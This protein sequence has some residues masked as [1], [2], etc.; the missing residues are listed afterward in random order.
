MLLQTSDMRN[1][2]SIFNFTQIL[3]SELFN[4]AKNKQQI[5]RS[6]QLTSISKSFMKTLYNKHGYVMNI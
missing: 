4:L 5:K 6:S 3:N 2:T 1:A